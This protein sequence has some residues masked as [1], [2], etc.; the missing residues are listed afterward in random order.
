MSTTPSAAACA[1]TSASR[2]VRLHNSST[3]A[4]SASVPVIET[5]YDHLVARLHAAAQPEGA[6]PAAAAAYVEKVRTGAYTVT[7]A[8]VEALE[9][10]GLS[11]DEIFELTVSTA[12][13]V[14]VGRLEKG[15]EVLR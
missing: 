8:D 6:V 2:R 15:L 3:E 5:R 9:A 11:E 7:D 14:G 1:T 4:C 13:G 12:V 10:A